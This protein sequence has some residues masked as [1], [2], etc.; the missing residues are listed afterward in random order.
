MIV[1]PDLSKVSIRMVAKFR[2]RFSRPYSYHL[3]DWCL[4]QIPEYD[5]I[6]EVPRTSI[7]RLLVISF[8]G[9]T[10]VQHRDFYTDQIKPILE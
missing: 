5:P 1:S 10:A 6:H 4:L 9:S 2:E 3:C 7:A 8:L